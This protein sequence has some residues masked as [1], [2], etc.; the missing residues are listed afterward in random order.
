MNEEVPRKLRTKKLLAM[1]AFV[2]TFLLPKILC[3]F[4][5]SKEL[6]DANRASDGRL[7]D[8]A[9]ST[10]LCSIDVG[11]DIGHIRKKHVRPCADVYVKTVEKIKV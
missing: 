8:A 1:T 10:D 9:A 11:K 6:L 3:I 4:K 5:S 2:G 7:R